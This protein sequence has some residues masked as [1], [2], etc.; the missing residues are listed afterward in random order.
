MAIKLQNQG[1]EI[2]CIGTELL[3]G[4]ILNTN[5]KWLAEQLALIGLPHYQ[6]SVVGDNPNRL[7]A[8]L[9]DASRRSRIL[10]TTGGL[11]PTPDDLTTEIIAETFNNKLIEDKSIVKDLKSKFQ[12]HAQITK[13]NW[14]QALV[15]LGASIL[16]NPLGTAPGIIWTPKENFTVITFPGVP[17]EMKQMWEESAKPWLV[18][19]CPSE[20][21]FTSKI[22]KFTGITES[23]LA[24]KIPELL[25]NKNP[26]VAPYASIGEV[27][28][29]ITAQTK[30]IDEANTQISALET[31]LKKIIGSHYFYGSNNETLPSVVI[32][33]LRRRK[34]TLSIAE[35]CTGGSLAAAIT[36][37]PGASDV[38]LGGVIAYNNKIKKELLGVSNELLNQYGAVSEPVAKAMASGIRRSFKT[39]WSIA[40]SGIAGPTGSTGDKKVGLVEIFIEGK[41]SSESIQENFGIYRQR[42]QIQ[43]LSVVRALDRLR[44]FLLNKS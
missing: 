32:D 24:E 27:K 6:Q 42:T 44:L 20:K 34:E 19:N 1:I 14:K 31:Q 26:T 37:I 36:A 23:S 29:R 30:T 35:S 3:L 40:I 5:A 22:L 12:S 15:P 9:L 4:N 10:I 13:N 41:T 38:F 43:K 39:D 17:S 11:G 2:L 28:L 25:S 16:P 8:F 7:K 18:K 33:L 21:I